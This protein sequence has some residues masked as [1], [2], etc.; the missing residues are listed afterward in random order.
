VQATDDLSGV[1]TNVWSSAT[2]AFGAGTD[3]FETI[4]VI[5]PV[6]PEDVTVGRFLRLH[7]TRP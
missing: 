2:N 1:W 7:V 3:D 4:T 6:A 5:D